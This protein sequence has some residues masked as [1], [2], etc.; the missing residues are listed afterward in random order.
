M[1]FLDA[2]ILLEITLKERLHFLAVQQYLSQINGPTAISMLSVHLLMHFG[3][4]AQISDEFLHA[5]I[6]EN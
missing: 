6:N 1:I 4:K 3:R 2:N 5:V